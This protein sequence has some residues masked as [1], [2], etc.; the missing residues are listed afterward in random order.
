MANKQQQKGDKKHRKLTKSPQVSCDISM[1]SSSPTTPS[2]FIG[3]AS[4]GKSAT[5]CVVLSQSNPSVTYPL[6]PPPK[7]VAYPSSFPNLPNDECLLKNY[8]YSRADVLPTD[9][10]QSFTISPMA[11]KG[12]DD[13]HRFHHHQ[14]IK[15][16][17]SLKIQ[18]DI[19]SG[20]INEPSASYASLVDQQIRQNIVYVESPVTMPACCVKSSMNAGIPTV[21]KYHQTVIATATS[22]LPSTHSGQIL[23]TPSP[24]SAS[25]ATTFSDHL[26]NIKHMFQ[27]ASGITNSS[28]AA[29]I[30]SSGF[31]PVNVIS[32]MTTAIPKNSTSFESTNPFALGNFFK[33]NDKTTAAGGAAGTAL[34]T[35]PT[36]VCGSVGSCTTISDNIKRDEVLKATM[37]ICLVVSPPSNKLLQVLFFLNACEIRYLR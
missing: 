25:A 32:S 8:E 15:T 4:G 14:A 5:T 35:T 16:V 20:R 9:N 34:I 27:S 6:N 33:P 36:T 28:T 22:P 30:S 10:I 1:L 23:T 24:S 31:V 13:L 29:T 17:D 12:N 7:H 21:D 18:Q 19:R 37:K 11:T 26:R 2:G 3:S